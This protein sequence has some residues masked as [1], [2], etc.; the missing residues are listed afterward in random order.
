[1]K[2]SYQSGLTFVE[3]SLT[4]A[5]LSITASI[6]LPELTKFVASNRNQAAMH[7]LHS[8]LQQARSQ[9]VNRKRTLEL[10]PSLDGLKCSTNWMHPRLLRVL[11]NGQPLS[12]TAAHAGS[13]ELR[14]A[15]FS[16]SIRFYNTGI[17]P[18]SNGRFFICEE[19]VISQQ[20]I[21]NKQGRIRWGRKLENQEESTRC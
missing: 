10:C 2:K 8:L 3:L 7:E 21:I 9:A 5:V 13:S 20:L 15:G 14:W 12:H 6:A 16:G 18:I 11:S 17:S 4:L 19:K 1:M